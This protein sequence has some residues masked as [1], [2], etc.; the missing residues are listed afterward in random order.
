MNQSIMYGW[1]SINA[2]LNHEIEYRYP[3]RD[4]QEVLCT[5]ITP[6]KECSYTTDK[7]LDDVVF[8]GEVIINKFDTTTQPPIKHPHK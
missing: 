6:T 5:L 3:N 4:K 1:F 8:C 7:Y 2:Y